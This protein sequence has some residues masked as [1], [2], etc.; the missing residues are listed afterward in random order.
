[1]EGLSL[2]NIPVDLLLNL[3]N[4][5]LLFLIVRALVYTP[6]RK[7]LD[8]RTERIQNQEKAAAEKLAEAERLKT[9]YGEMLKQGEAEARRIEEGRAEQASMEAEKIVSEA[10]K[11]A[12][13]LIDEARER[14]EAEKKE[15]ML[16]MK[17]EVAELALE[18]SEKILRREI[19]D[20]D[21]RRIAEEFFAADI[22]K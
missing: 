9:E 6:V 3:I 2:S 19:N 22:K 10:K 7:F 4:I 12:N 5:V 1:M 18:I 13:A 15:A 16:G 17:N 20:R 21:N 11:K 8:A 14:S